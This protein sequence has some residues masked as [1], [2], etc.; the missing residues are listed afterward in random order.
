MVKQGFLRKFVVHLAGI[1]LLG[2][3]IALFVCTNLGA[4]PITVLADGVHR[5]LSMTI[6]Q[7]MIFLNVLVLAVVVVRHRKYIRIGT[8]TSALMTGVFTD[9]WL[10]CL[11]NAMDNVSSL[12]VR[13]AILVVS[14]GFSGL[15]IAM[16]M[17]ADIGVCLGDLIANILNKEK[18]YQYRWI[19]I[20]IDVTCLSVGFCLGG[21]VGLGTVVSAMLTGPAVQACMPV[22]RR[23][24][25]GATKEH[26]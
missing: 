20:V 21:K 8:W 25:S 19:K 14:C 13:I 12:W 7:A 24:A 26:T 22:A 9:L 2:L 23:F 1:C 18:G 11:G 17:E 5:I 3:G 15:G 16:Y 6:G 4:D 10:M